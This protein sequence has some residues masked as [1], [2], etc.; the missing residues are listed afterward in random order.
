MEL[1]ALTKKSAVALTSA[2]LL[3]TAVFATS[4][5]SPTP[6]THNVE[7]GIS[8]QAVVDFSTLF[9]VT[10]PISL[11]VVIDSNGMAQML[12]VQRQR[13]SRPR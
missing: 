7:D 3:S 12:F 13:P 1:L 4:G 2:A 5:G 8:A 9:D 6:D 10:V 11:P